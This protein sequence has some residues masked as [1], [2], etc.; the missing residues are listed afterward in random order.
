M[1]NRPT[2]ENLRRPH[3]K[4]RCPVRCHQLPPEDRTET[5]CGASA[6]RN[7]WDTFWWHLLGCDGDGGESH[8]QM[9]RIRLF[10]T[11]P[12]AKVQS[13]HAALWEVPISTSRRVGLSPLFIF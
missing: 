10:E 12:T 3:P 13:V 11:D 4:C 2:K 7:E 6:I 9:R 8:A 5:H 1:A